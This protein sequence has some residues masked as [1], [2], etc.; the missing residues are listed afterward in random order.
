MCS[1]MTGVEKGRVGEVKMR[2]IRGD[3]SIIF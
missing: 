2:V 1:E 3:I